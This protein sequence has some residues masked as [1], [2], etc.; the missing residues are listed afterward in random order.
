MQSLIHSPSG[1][2]ITVIIQIDNAVNLNNCKNCGAAIMLVGFVL[3]KV[4]KAN[5]DVFRLD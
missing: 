3:G 2:G 4:Y 1:F 5:S